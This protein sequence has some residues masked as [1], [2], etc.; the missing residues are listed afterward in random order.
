MVTN[1]YTPPPAPHWITDEQTFQAISRLLDTFVACSLKQTGS[2]PAIPYDETWLSPCLKL[3]VDSKP[4]GEAVWQPCLRCASSP[5]PEGLQKAFDIEIHAAFTAYFSSYWSEGIVVDSP[6]GQLH[7]IQLWNEQDEQM[8]GENLIGHL[9]MQKK[10]RL[11]PTLFFACGLAESVICIDNSSGKIVME[12]PGKAPHKVLAN[13]M[14][15]FLQQLQ[16]TLIRY[17]D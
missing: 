11:S 8:L 16:P 9:M 14:P 12:L 5:I 3:P 7:L 17:S 4:T 10:K 6:W 15:E 2:L 1:L 13:S